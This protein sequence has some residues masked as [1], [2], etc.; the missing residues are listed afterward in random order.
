MRPCPVPS[1]ANDGVQKW[2]RRHGR[3]R[4]NVVIYVTRSN[5]SPEYVGRKAQYENKQGNIEKKRKRL[6]ARTL[7]GQ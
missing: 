5:R 6:R 3:E 4:G 7:C 1:F 2:T